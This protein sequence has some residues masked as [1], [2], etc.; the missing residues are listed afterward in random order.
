MGKGWRL[1]ISGLSG[2]AT[3]DMYHSPRGRHDQPYACSVR[4]KR[5][6]YTLVCQVASSQRTCTQL[7]NVC[8]SAPVHSSSV[9]VIGFSA[10]GSVNAIVGI[11]AMH[12][13]VEG[14]G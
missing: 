12:I 14:N 3:G 11:E 2:R 7:R 13:L 6:K 10:S 4:F 1:R 5:R 8:R 9:D